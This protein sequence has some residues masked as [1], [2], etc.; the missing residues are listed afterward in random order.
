MS[1]LLLDVI[2][3]WKLSH[4]R[5]QMRPPWYSPVVIFV[6]RMIADYMWCMTRDVLVSQTGEHCETVLKI[7]NC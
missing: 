2:V 7:G 5:K 6:S 4:A 1:V 3:F